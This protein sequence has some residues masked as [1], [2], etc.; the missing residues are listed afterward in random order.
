MKW[1]SFPVVH[2]PY[3]RAAITGTE[4]WKCVQRAKRAEEW[5]RESKIKENFETCTGGVDLRDEPVGEQQECWRENHKIVDG[6]MWS[7]QNCRK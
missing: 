2:I 3:R 6:E 5:K 1:I 4:S 7:Q